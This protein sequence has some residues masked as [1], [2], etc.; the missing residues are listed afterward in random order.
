M[1]LLN[2]ANA[3]LSHFNAPEDVPGGYAILSHVWGN[4][5]LTFKEINDIYAECKASTASSNTSGEQ[6]DVPL[7]PINPPPRTHKIVSQAS[8]LDIVSRRVLNIF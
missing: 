6:R 2:T 1:W 7:H 3:R 8:T 4:H 5:E